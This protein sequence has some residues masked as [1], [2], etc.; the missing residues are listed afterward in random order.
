MIDNRIFS[1]ILVLPVATSLSGK[2]MDFDIRKLSHFSPLQKETM[3]A[4]HSG[5]LGT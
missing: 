2:K 4:T 5:L 1:P 3:F